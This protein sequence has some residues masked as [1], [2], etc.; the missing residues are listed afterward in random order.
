MPRRPFGSLDSFLAGAEAPP[1]V[2]SVS[3]PAVRA[4]NRSTT[5]VPPTPPRDPYSW[6]QSRC[7]LRALPPVLPP[8]PKKVH[9][10]KR[11]KQRTRGHLA[12][13][14]LGA[15]TQW[16]SPFG[17][18]DSNHLMHGFEADDARWMSSEN[19][20]ETEDAAEEEGEE[21]HIIRETE[22]D[23]AEETVSE[24]AAN[25][26]G[27]A[28]ALKN[29]Q[30]VIVLQ[31]N[32][33]LNLE[34][35]EK[36][37]QDAVQL[38]TL[39]QYPINPIARRSTFFGKCRL[40]SKIAKHTTA[41]AKHRGRMAEK[42]QHAIA[43]A[44][45]ETPRTGQIVAAYTHGL[46]PRPS[47]MAEVTQDGTLD[48]SGRGLGDHHHRMLLDFLRRTRLAAHV[49]AAEPGDAESAVPP[50][51]RVSLRSNRLGDAAAAEIVLA[52]ARL[53]TDAHGLV[54]LD[55]S[56]N[57]L[58]RKTA[59]ALCQLVAVT[60]ASLQELRVSGSFPGV[61]SHRALL[62]GLATVV[63]ESNKKPKQKKSNGKRTSCCLQVLD[64]S[65]NRIDSAAAIAS[66][67][68]VVGLLP[69]LRE[70]H[71]DWNNLGPRGGMQL[72]RAVQQNATNARKRW[73]KLE[74]P[75]NAGLHVLGLSFNRI[76]DEAALVLA[77]ALAS[78]HPQLTELFVDG[79][80]LGDEAAMALADAM[81]TARA[82]ARRS[83]VRACVLSMLHNHIGTRVGNEMLE[84][85]KREGK[86]AGAKAAH[87]VGGALT[88]KVYPV[89]VGDGEGSID[90]LTAF[91]ALEGAKK[92]V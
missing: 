92:R 84:R 73:S 74:T 19:M 38:E 87:R 90:P 34:A 55:L 27:D 12:R 48:L 63:T 76:G 32:N 49:A 23:D 78:P 4:W 83:K 28:I 33:R 8:P 85:N 52:L 67:A 1:L 66:L 89:S 53:D 6:Y 69:S 91:G 7:R 51:L 40:A 11:A 60:G 5:V 46:V 70:C 43:H 17:G 64:L 37:V 18:N 21:G 9:P 41:S 36:A 30:E 81:R 88:V 72:A 13:I 62:A 59:A 39:S 71:L 82:T 14:Q 15:P 61:M 75:A 26:R 57:K 25:L 24:A 10:R 45:P 3:A 77:R 65:H 20:S 58:G 54:S 16:L 80:H 86:E 2:R 68:V 56:N 44:T 47:A 35:A 50:I 29:G 42:T 31:D 22:H 79:C